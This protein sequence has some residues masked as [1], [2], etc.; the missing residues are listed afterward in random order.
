MSQPWFRV[1]AFRLTP[2]AES[3]IRHDPLTGEAVIYSTARAE[4]PCELATPATPANPANTPASSAN[5]PASLAN[6]DHPSSSDHPAV[7]DCPFC[8]GHEDQT[9]PA[10]LTVPGPDGNWLARAVPNRYPALGSPA[11]APLHFVVIECP[12]HQRNLSAC[13][14]EQIAAV[15]DLHLQLHLRLYALPGVEYVQSFKNVGYEAGASLL[16]SHSQVLALPFVPPLV[17]RQWVQA[18]DYWVLSRHCPWCQELSQ[19]YAQGERLIAESSGLLAYA[20]RVSP[21]PCQVRIAPI[22]HSSRFETS[23]PE[24]I[25]ELASLLKLL[26]TRLDER[27]AEPPYNL[28]IRTAP[29]RLGELPFGHWSIDI[30]PRL[31]G[32]AG[33]EWATGCNINPVPPEQAAAY[34]RQPD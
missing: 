2:L 34:L 16:H 31:T 22:M 7:A 29:A 5:T 11:T 4:R 26:L 12:D 13:S 14:V 1:P 19:E 8:V 6:P 33:F 18:R 27:L 21:M 24:I 30:I 10:V 17:Q 20:P 9:P 25:G 32:L 28:T 3:E 23:S 15:L